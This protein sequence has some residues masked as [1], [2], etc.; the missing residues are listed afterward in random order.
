MFPLLLSMDV[1]WPVAWILLWLSWNDDLWPGIISQ[2]SPFLN[3]IM[4]G[5]SQQQKSRPK[6]NTYLKLMCN[7]I[8][9]HTETYAHTIITRKP[10]SRDGFQL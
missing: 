7:Y 1:M 3:Y 5:E 6:E 4:T 8:Y 10:K 9:A 2:I